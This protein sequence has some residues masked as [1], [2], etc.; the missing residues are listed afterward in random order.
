MLSCKLPPNIEMAEGKAMTMT[1]RP[2]L[3]AGDVLIHLIMIFDTACL[4][5]QFPRLRAVM[6][7]HWGLSVIA[8]LRLIE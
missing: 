4:L 3:T 7:D 2:T 6:G 1:L 5:S 8:P